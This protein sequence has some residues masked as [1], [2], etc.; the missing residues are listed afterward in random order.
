MEE[1][2]QFVEE[3]ILQFINIKCKEA[4]IFFCSP[5]DADGENDTIMNNTTFYKRHPE[6]FE[7][8]S[9]IIQDV[10]NFDTFTP[11]EKAVW[12]RTYK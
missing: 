4:A 11:S 7:L 10:R 8:Q 9:R 2:K 6:V 12:I 1:S 5:T 3:S